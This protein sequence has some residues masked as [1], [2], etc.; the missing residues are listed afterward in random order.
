MSASV[1]SGVLHSTSKKTGGPI[2]VEEEVKVRRFREAVEAVRN[3]LNAG[4]ADDFQ[5]VDR[6][7]LKKVGQRRR[8]IF[9][10]TLFLC[11]GVGKGFNGKGAAGTKLAEISEHIRA[12]DRRPC[13]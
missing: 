13:V 2:S 8:G 12:S 10:G 11:F 4:G 3:E 1:M 6:G 5:H 9:A 7:A